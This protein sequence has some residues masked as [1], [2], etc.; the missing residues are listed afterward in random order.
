MQ[1]YSG[2]VTGV[3][4]LPIRRKIGNPSKGLYVKCLCVVLDETTRI[5][6]R[7]DVLKNELVVIQLSGATRHQNRHIGY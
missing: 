2:R 5:K 6:N 1:T 4:Q 3:Q 7:Q